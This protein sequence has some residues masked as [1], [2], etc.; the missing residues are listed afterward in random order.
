M[1]LVDVESVVGPPRYLG[2]CGGRTGRHNRRPLPPGRPTT[3]LSKDGI[4]WD[5]VWTVTL[6]VAKEGPG[7][8]SGTGLTTEE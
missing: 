4:Q 7:V 6:T 8:F 5:S 1:S 2:R 3:E